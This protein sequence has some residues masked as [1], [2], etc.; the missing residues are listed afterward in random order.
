M[1]DRHFHCV[2]FKFGKETHLGGECLLKKKEIKLG[3]KPCCEHIVLRPINILSY[4]LKHEKYCAD[5][6]CADKKALEY[7]D[8]A[9]FN[10]Y[11][12]EDT[13]DR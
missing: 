1:T 7:I 5:W 4:F 12:K 13:N 6:E 10:T 3:F 11:P 9:G 2:Y 8:K